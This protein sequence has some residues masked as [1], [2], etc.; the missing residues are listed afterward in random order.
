MFHLH[1]G[2]LETH[3]SD[4]LNETTKNAYILQVN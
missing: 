1:L 3:S 2:Y 4:G